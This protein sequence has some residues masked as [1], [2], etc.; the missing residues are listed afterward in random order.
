MTA[1]A[2]LAK[3]WIVG[4]LGLA[5]TAAAAPA[6]TPATMRLAATL[7]VTEAKQGKSSP[8]LLPLI[9]A[10]ARAE[11]VTGALDT[12]TTL[13]RRAL[14][15]AITAYG[16]GAVRSAAAMTELAW[17]YLDQG[18]YLDAEPLLIAANRIFASRPDAP[19]AA[20][21]MALAGR[22]RVAVAHGDTDAAIAAARNAVSASPAKSR[23]SITALRALAAALAAGHR[24]DEAE[25]VLRQALALDKEGHEP[26][27][28]TARTLSQMANLYL[29]ADRAADAL[30]LIEEATAIDQEQ[31]GTDHPFIAD[32]LHDL[33]LVYEALKR[34]SEARRVLGAALDRLERGGAGDTTRAGYTE[35]DLSRVLGKMGD[36]D[37]AETAFRNA[38]RI[39][40][41]AEAE[42]HKR[43]RKV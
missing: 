25:Q 41:K 6:E 35:S 34:L 18:R 27:G 42:E 10:L 21:A 11:F 8:A 12:T 38:R 22:A 19:V 33:G 20:K 14:T 16:S 17:A 26:A 39:L 15:I 2:L 40:N 32:D 30:P 31:L 29:H 36:E 43:E 3:A 13:R 1:R 24:V 5:L 28:G 7:A 37:A 4:G 9:D 23:E